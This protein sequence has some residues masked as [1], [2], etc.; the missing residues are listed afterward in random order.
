MHTKQLFPAVCFCK[1]LIP[2]ALIFLLW[3]NTLFKLGFFFFRVL[4]KIKSKLLLFLLKHFYGGIE[5]NFDWLVASIAAPPI[6]FF[7]KIPLHKR[8]LLFFTSHNQPSSLALS[9]GDTPDR[10]LFQATHPEEHV[11]TELWS[12]FSFVLNHPKNKFIYEF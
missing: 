10:L 1:D 5:M 6:C 4:L 8:S 9:E 3:L 2:D 11:Q 12:L 7:N